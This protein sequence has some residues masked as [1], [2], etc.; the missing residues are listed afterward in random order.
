[1]FE[2]ATEGML[3]VNEQG[4][5]IRINPS[6]E[7]L[8]GYAKGELL[9]QKI[10]TLVPRNA[11]ERH[12][13]YRTKYK[14]NPHARSM[15]A[16]I[17]LYGRKKDGA[18]FPVEVSLSPYV[19]EN[20]RFV[21]A[22]IVDVTTRKQAEEKMRNYS[23]ELEKQVEDRTMILHEA[24][25]E[26]EKTKA[27]LHEALQKERELN[28]LKSRFVSVASHEFRTPLTTIAS[29]VSLVKRYAE[30]N[31][32]EKQFRHI[33]RIKSAINNLTDILDDFLSLSKLEEGKVSYMPEL[34]NLSAFVKEITSEMQINAKH[35]QTIAYHHDGD[36]Y[37]NVDPK[38]LKNILLNLV[39]N[40]I[41]FSPEDQPVDVTSTV[42][43]NIVTLTIA[44]HGVGIPQADRGHLFERFYRGNNVTN[45]QGTGLGLSIVAKYVE[46]VNG[47]IDYTSEENKGTT[48]IVTFPKG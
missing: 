44:D 34:F 5:I 26:L 10:E 43:G 48:F 14:Q 4:E 36:I 9:N 38:V 21:I 22:F 25:A 29:S 13:Q 11:A 32:K 1:M 40:A 39:S 8:F 41:K 27:E 2:H 45:V 31:D 30:T 47:T 19:S 33:E 46:L 28:D 37:V 7:R 15:G 18:E 3:I 42:N 17:D 35:G 24:I 16:G 6:A 12:E 23:S 20:G